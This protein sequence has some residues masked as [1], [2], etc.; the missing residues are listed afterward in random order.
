VARL[1]YLL[2]F[3]SKGGH[4]H[5]ILYNLV[6][7]KQIKRRLELGSLFKGSIV[8]ILAGLNRLN[9]L[10]NLEVFL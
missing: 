7:G 8:A 2:A 10:F 6:L 3:R 9:K 5:F 4:F 1:G